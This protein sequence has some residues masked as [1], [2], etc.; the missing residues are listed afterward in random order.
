MSVSVNVQPY[1]E[2]RLLVTSNSY[3]DGATPFVT[4]VVTVPGQG[5]VAVFLRNV[6][7]ARSLLDAAVEAYRKCEEQELERR[8][9]AEL[10]KKLPVYGENTVAEDL[11]VFG[12][13]T[14]SEESYNEWLNGGGDRGY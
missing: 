6:D 11:S 12:G 10:T 1:G 5:N 2:D 14:V 8:I 4:L 13:N 9:D 7:D 3:S